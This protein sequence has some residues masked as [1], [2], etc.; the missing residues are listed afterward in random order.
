MPFLSETFNYGDQEKSGVS[1]DMM[2]ALTDSYEE[3]AEEVNRKADLV[4]RT[5]A[6]AGVADGSGNIPSTTD[7]NFR[8]GTIYIVQLTSPPIPDPATD[9]I[10]M[11][12]Q[13]IINAGVKTALWMLL[14]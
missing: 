4:I 6:P 3:T 9:Q 12:T 1:E 2:R 10:F 13:T 8:N 5:T 14:N 7:V 11:K